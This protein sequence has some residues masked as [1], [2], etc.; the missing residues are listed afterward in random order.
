MPGNLI[1]VFIAASLMLFVAAASAHDGPT[2]WDSVKRDMRE[3]VYHDRNVSEKGTVYCGCDWEWRGRSGGRIILDDSC[4]FE[5]RNN[6]TRGE[7]IEWEHILPA[8]TM[9]WWADRECWDEGGRSECSSEDPEYVAKYTDM[10]NLTPSIGEMNSDRSNFAFSSVNR[11]AKHGVCDSRVNF[12]ERTF[13]P[14]DE[15]KGFVARAY[16]YMAYTYD[17]PLPR[18]K[19]RTLMAWDE[20]HPPTAWERERNQRIA[21]RIGRENPFIT[22]DRKWRLDKPASGKGLDSVNGE[23]QAQ[24]DES[25]YEGPVRGNT[26]SNIYHLPNCPSYD[27]VGEQNRRHFESE[28]A[29]EEAGFRKAGNC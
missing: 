23:Y 9:A 22:G 11:P 24:D 19:Q 6:E 26:N 5:I 27:R 7:R 16:F 14:R 18:G 20:A 15:A 10:H 25:A 29:A 28:E 12:D 3:N 8:S 17:I 21:E 1:R 13:E 4:P 2:T